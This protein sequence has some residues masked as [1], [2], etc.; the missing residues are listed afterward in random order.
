MKPLKTL[1]VIAC[2][3]LLAGCGALTRS[4]ETAGLRLE[5]PPAE[6]VQEIAAP[7]RLPE[8]ELTQGDVERSWK[9]DRASL[10]IGRKRHRALVDW[11]A[12]RDAA[13]MGR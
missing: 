11:Y 3:C 10:V 1:L 7:V 5:A 4:G 9:A 6:M 13:L 12:A 8:R 2:A